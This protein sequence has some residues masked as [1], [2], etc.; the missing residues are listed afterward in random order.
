MWRAASEG[1]GFGP[2]TCC[3]QVIDE[4]LQLVCTAYRHSDFDTCSG[5]QQCEMVP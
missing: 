2:S 4:R 1:K 5:K 3:M